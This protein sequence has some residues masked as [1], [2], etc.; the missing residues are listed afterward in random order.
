MGLLKESQ[1]TCLLC[2]DAGK[3]S[4]PHNCFLFGSFVTT[5]GRPCEALGSQCFSSTPSIYWGAAVLEAWE[6]DNHVLLTITCCKADISPGESSSSPRPCVTRPAY[7]QASSVYL[8]AGGPLHGCWVCTQ[9]WRFQVNV[10]PSS[11][12]EQ[13]Q[14]TWVVK[15][16]GRVEIFYGGRGPLCIICLGKATGCRRERLWQI[17]S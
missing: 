12:S 11:T 4:S 16:L 14:S 10:L 5:R 1:A 8:Y 9:K 2:W 7:I 13:D 6:C 17:L 3:E 15:R